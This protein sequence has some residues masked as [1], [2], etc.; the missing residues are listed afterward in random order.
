MNWGERGRVSGVWE[1]ER[2]RVFGFDGSAGAVVSVADEDE[3]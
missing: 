1:G 3:C 2:G